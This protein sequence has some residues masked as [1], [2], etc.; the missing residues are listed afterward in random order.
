MLYLIAIVIIDNSSLQLLALMDR[1]SLQ[2]ED[3]LN[4]LQLINSS[5][6]SMV[7]VV[8][9][10]NSALTVNLEWM[11]NWLGGA[12]DGLHILT[13]LAIH[14]VFLILATLCLLFVKAPALARVALLVMITTNALAE[15]KLRVSLTLTAMT[16]IQVL[17]LAGEGYFK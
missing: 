9:A 4:N 16:T 12:Q 10:M 11:V 6:S 14:G 3:T 2:Y 8:T 13:T 7:E 5:V 1:M 15:V 17:L